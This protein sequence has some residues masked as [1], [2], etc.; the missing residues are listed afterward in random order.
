LPYENDIREA[1]R[2][3]EEVLS[4]LGDD[5][6]DLGEVKVRLAELANAVEESLA[7]ISRQIEEVQRAVR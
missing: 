5:V 6:S 3:A 7:A 1:F 4:R 2:K